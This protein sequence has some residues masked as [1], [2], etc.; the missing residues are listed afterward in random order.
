MLI[1]AFYIFSFAILHSVMLYLQCSDMDCES[2]GVGTRSRSLHCISANGSRINP[3]S[4][5]SPPTSSSSSS[6][7]RHNE[8]MITSVTVPPSRQTCSNELCQTTWKSFVWSKVHICAS[9]KL[10]TRYNIDADSINY[11]YG[12]I[13]FYLIIWTCHT[14]F[15]VERQLFQT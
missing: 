11:R 8:R 2:V 4:C 6:Q 5:P 15:L 7:S 14:S 3:S 9:V 1:L 10:S 13:Q 12:T